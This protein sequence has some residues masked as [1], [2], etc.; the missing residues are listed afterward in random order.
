MKADSADQEMKAKPTALKESS[1]WCTGDILPVV[2]IHSALNHS[3]FRAQNPTR[4]PLPN[5]KTE[6]YRC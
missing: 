6:S 4:I 2:D 1:L 5:N 3:T